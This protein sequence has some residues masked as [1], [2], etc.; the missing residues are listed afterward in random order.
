MAF[1]NCVICGTGIDS[2]SNNV[3]V[4]RTASKGVRYVCLACSADKK[5][6]DFDNSLKAHGEKKHGKTL[7]FVLQTLG[8][9]VPMMEQAAFYGWIKAKSDSPLISEWRTPKLQ[10][11]CGVQ[12]QLRTVEKAQAL[13]SATCT[14]PITVTAKEFGYAQATLA[15]LNISTLSQGIVRE[16]LNNPE[17]C[18]KLFGTVYQV[19]GKDWMRF[20]DNGFTLNMP[21]F[22][23]AEQYMTCI[24]F[25]WDMMEILKKTRLVG[26][27]T[28][29]EELGE[30]L[31]RLYC[32]Y[33]KVEW[34]AK[35]WAC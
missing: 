20:N 27:S 30:R 14:A 10:S 32:K 18:K 13:T 5:A 33:A 29:F 35:K 1:C 31:T 24:R 7:S 3:K 26:K 28:T 6:K 9:N 21:R 17:K 22:A 16:M 34:R 19:G 23:D 15:R 2:N 11:L 8:D 12:K 25:A 4:L